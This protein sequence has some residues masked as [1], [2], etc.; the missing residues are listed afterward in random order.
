MRSVLERSA[1]P[2]AGLKSV[3]ESVAEPVRYFDNNLGSTLALLAWDASGMDLS[4]AAWSG[5]TAGFPL[6]DNWWLTAVMHD[7]AHW[8]AWAL[9]LLLALAAWFTPLPRLNNPSREQAT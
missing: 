3:G 9:V 7:G 2:L 1:L 6:R 8:L 4:L 5:S